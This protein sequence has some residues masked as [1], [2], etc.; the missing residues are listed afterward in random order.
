MWPSP[1]TTFGE[2][3]AKAAESWRQRAPCTPGRWPHL[4]EVPLQLGVS[5]LSLA[6]LAVSCAQLVLQLAHLAAQH[7]QALPQLAH[8]G[9]LPLQGLLQLRCAPVRVP[10]GTQAVS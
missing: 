3:W 9:P 7:G 10:A 6:Q 8:L 2:L 4:L 1:G 5:L